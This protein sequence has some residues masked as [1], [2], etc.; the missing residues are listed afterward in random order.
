M[1][2]RI[3]EPSRAIAGV[4]GQHGYGFAFFP[5]SRGPKSVFLLFRS[6]EEAERAHEQISDVLKETL[7]V[8]I[9]A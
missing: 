2:H 7:E 3:T 6:K 1:A 8:F 4:G 5:D 9:H